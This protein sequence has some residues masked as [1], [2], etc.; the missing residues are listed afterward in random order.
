[1]GC[2]AQ[3]VSDAL[4]NIVWSAGNVP[5]PPVVEHVIAIWNMLGQEQS[6][7][8]NILLAQA[9]FGR[10]SPLAEYYNVTLVVNA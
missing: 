9:H 7:K 3:H 8:A 5:S 10:D 4:S 6:V 2:S 1:M